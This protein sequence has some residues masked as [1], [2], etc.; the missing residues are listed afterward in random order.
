MISEMKKV[1]GVENGGRVLVSTP[2]A[3][4]AGDAFPNLGRHSVSVFAKHASRHR[5]GTH[6]LHNDGRFIHRQYGRLP[7]PLSVG[8]VCSFLFLVGKE[9][10]DPVCLCRS[11]PCVLGEYPLLTS[12]FFLFLY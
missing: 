8:S 5:I 1:F 12:C 6:G 11:T 3:S 9:S 2:P 7:T 4:D 10:W